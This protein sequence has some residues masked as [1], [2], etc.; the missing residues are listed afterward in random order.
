MLR[1]WRSAAYWL[2]LHGLLSL[3]SCRTQDLCRHVIVHCVKSILA[4]Y[5]NAGFDAPGFGCKTLLS[6][7]SLIG[8]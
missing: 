2:V 1:P 7:Y 8:Q 3:L 6:N 5:S 4:Y